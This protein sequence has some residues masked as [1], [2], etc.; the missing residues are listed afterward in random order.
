MQGLE[1]YIEKSKEKLIKAVNNNNTD[2]IRM[3]K[4]NNNK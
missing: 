2:N 4:Q 3:D 1:D